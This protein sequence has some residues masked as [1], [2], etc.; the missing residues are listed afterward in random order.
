MLLECYLWTHVVPI[1]IIFRRRLAW[2]NDWIYIYF[3]P[4]LKKEKDWMPHFLPTSIAYDMSSSSEPSI[5]TGNLYILIS[6]WLFY[7]YHDSS[8]TIR[9]VI[10]FW[11]FNICG[12]CYMNYWVLA[13]MYWLNYGVGEIL[14]HM[15]FYAIQFQS[16]HL[17]VQQL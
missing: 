8:T 10:K 7:L 16:S 3:N 6:C 12:L 15:Q 4:F 11:G 14:F 2:N 9:N 13:E 5:S 17:E 1:M